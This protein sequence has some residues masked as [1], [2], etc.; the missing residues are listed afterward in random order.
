L[1]LAPGLVGL[2]AVLGLPAAARATPIASINGNVITITDTAGTADDVIIATTGLD[3]TGVLWKIAGATAG[4]GCLA[5]DPLIAECSDGSGPG[6]R[7]SCAISLGDGND[8]L[9]FRD[10]FVGSVRID[11]GAGNDTLFSSTPGPQA[12][13]GGPG[14]DNLNF[15]ANSG[16]VTVDGG[17]GNDNI[18]ADGSFTGDD[19][20]GGAGIDT[21]TYAAR[22]EQGVTV[23][24]DDVA[25]DGRQ[26]P[27]EGDNIHSDVENVTGTFLAD[28]LIGD[29]SANVLIGEAGNDQID[30]KSGSDTL[31]GGAG[32]DVIGQNPARACAAN[33]LGQ[34][35]CFPIFAG[36]SPDGFDT[37]NGGPGNDTLSTQDGAVDAAVHCG[38]G[39]DSVFVDLHDPPLAAGQNGCESVQNGQRNEHPLL[40]T[41]REVH[42]D[43]AGRVNLQLACPANHGRTCHGTLSL[44]RSKQTIGRVGYRI[45]AGLQAAVGVKLDAVA[46]L[47]H[48]VRIVALAQERD[49]QRKPVTSTV[50]VRLL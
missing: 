34:L 39:S 8:R 22:S 40:I 47:L 42:A 49:R 17:Q 19:V 38:E 1:W 7:R 27:A 32:D 36:S 15:E 12:V 37:I 33:S 3:A 43:R 44:F 26:S 29:A 30:G 21:V 31:I 16:A 41:T 46:S 4:P 11:M 10:F 50:L 24:L 35:A 25:N 9:V 6:P 13:Q 18:A 23:T 20:H 45:R 2:V 14:D 5:F 48:G 28:R